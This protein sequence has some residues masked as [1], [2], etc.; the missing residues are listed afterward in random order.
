MPSHPVNRPAPISV[1]SDRRRTKFNVLRRQLGQNLILGLDLFSPDTRCVPPRPRV[2]G[3]GFLLEG[4]RFILKKLLLP[5]I[6]NR[7]MRPMLIAR[8]EIGSFSNRYLLRIAT[9]SCA[10]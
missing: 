4:G 10:V 5:P 1:F 3:S 2:V 8:S 9:F 6:E 7:R